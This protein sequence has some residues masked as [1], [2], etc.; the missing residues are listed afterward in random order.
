[1]TRLSCWR[2][3]LLIALGASALRSECATAADEIRSGCSGGI[4]GGGAGLVLSRDGQLW[5][6]QRSRAN[7]D[8][9]RGALLGTDA[10]AALQLFEKARLG[11]FALI[12]Y[13]HSGNRTCWVELTQDEL[14]HG[15]YWTDPGS[16]PSLA[17]GLF[18][19]LQKLQR[20]LT[21]KRP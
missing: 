19:S 16:A 7:S 12:E 20:D 14:T 18:E 13:R 9:Q 11:G 5:N 17:V 4:T 6:W 3:V 1:M 15:V 8:L 2:L 10:Q 21:V